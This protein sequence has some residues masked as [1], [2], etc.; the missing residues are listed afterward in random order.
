[1]SYKAGDKVRVNGQPM[2]IRSWPI[3]DQGPYTTIHYIPDNRGGFSEVQ[4]TYWVGG[5]SIELDEQ[6]PT[7]E[8]E[9]VAEGD[10]VVESTAGEL[11]DEA[12]EHEASEDDDEPELV[13][14]PAE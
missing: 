10:G 11:P 6:L 8:L 1:V 2:E 3:D 14:V 9:L 12:G 7:P 13:T 5:S 4:G